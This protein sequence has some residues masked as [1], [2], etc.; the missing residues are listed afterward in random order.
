MKSIL[1]K[2]DYQVVSAKNG[3]SALAKAKANQFDLILLD[4]VL[5]DIDGLVL[6]QDIKKIE[7]F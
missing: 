5:P 3:Q 4:I 1:S 7:S 2:K 6:T